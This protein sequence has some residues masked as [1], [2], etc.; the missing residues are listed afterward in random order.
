MEARLLEKVEVQTSKPY[1]ASAFKPLL[2]SRQ[3]ISQIMWLSPKSRGVFCPHGVGGEGKRQN[4]VD[5]SRGWGR[6]DVFEQTSNLSYLA[7]QNH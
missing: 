4:M 1:R 2:A 3:L 7:I 5:G 6:N